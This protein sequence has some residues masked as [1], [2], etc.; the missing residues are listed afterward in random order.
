[1]RA[2]KG[3]RHSGAVGKDQ[4]GDYCNS[5]EVNEGWE[6][7]MGYKEQELEIGTGMRGVLEEELMELWQFNVSAEREVRDEKHLCLLEK[8]TGE[9]RDQEFDV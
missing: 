8:Y 6:T 4:L 2:A 5:V 1:M 7:E 3:R 9:K